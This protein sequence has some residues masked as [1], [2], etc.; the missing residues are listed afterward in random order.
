MRLK[1]QRIIAGMIA[2]LCV[3]IF[4]NQVKA[5]ALQANGGEP[6]MKNANE[7]ICYIRQMQEAGGALGLTDTVHYSATNYDGNN[8]ETCDLKSNNTNL[9]IHMEK[10]TEYGA[11]VLLSASSYGN[12]N[13]IGDGDT[14]TGNKTGVV[15][16]LNGE[17][18]AAGT[19][20]TAAVCMYYASKRYWDDYGNNV[21]WMG[22]NAS[23]EKHPKAGDALEDP[24]PT[25]HGSS[26]QT[27]FLSWFDTG[28]YPDSPAFVK[29][30]VLRR[31][32]AG[33]VYSHNGH[34]LTYHAGW[35]VQYSHVEYRFSWESSSCC[36]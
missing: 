28:S 5:A 4:P 14:T 27:W 12:P 2:I 8:P 1:K 23:M 20:D 30:G 11:M 19:S 35:R 15:M 9:D 26:D 3:L 32:N 16:H 18:V 34:G 7:W 10:N 22:R 25:W 21:Y 29:Y 36:W 17:R 6:A 13:I 31:G 33:S 24:I